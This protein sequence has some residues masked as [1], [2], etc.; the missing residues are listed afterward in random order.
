[1]KKYQIVLVDDETFVLKALERVL[2]M[3][4]QYVVT[5]CQSPEQA[6]AQMET[7][8]PD[9]VLS[10]YKMPGMDGIE[11]LKWVKGKFPASIRIL[12]T[13]STEHQV[14]VRAINEGEVFR[15]IVK[16]WN[17]EDLLMNVKNGLIQRELW[18]E[19]QRLKERVETQRKFIEVLEKEHPG[20]TKKSEDEVYPLSQSETSPVSLAD[21]VKKY[22]PES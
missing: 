5:A 22:F 13:V 2:S 15:F 12:L 19:N 6:I 20:I 11:F 16:P 4:P 3:I 1:M 7:L 17:N 9:M 18:L 8:V 21:F 10:D 14:A